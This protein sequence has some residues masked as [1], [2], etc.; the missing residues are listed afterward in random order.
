[1]MRL[2]ERRAF[3]ANRALIKKELTE[4]MP[5]EDADVWCDAWEAEAK[6]LGI[7]RR[8]P[9]FWTVGS[10]WIRQQKATRRRAS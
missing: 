5:S 8:T 7:D 3:K 2:L 4:G 9:D 6:R 10:A 1:M